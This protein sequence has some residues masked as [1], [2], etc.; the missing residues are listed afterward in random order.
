MKDLVPKWLEDP[1]A[2]AQPANLDMSTVL[3]VAGINLLIGCVCVTIFEVLRRRWPGMY[4]PKEAHLPGS[5][6]KV[7][8]VPGE[9]PGAPLSW[10]RPLMALDEEKVLRCGGYDVLVYL[11][12]IRMAMRI[13]GSFAPYAFVVLLPVN[14]SVFYLDPA[15]TPPA[16]DEN[17]VVNTFN[18]LS[19]SSMPIRDSRMWAHCLGVYLLTGLT[20][21]VL[22]R[23]SCWYARLRHRF[24]TERGEARQRTVLV[25]R[26]HLELRSSP[27]LAEYFSRLYPGKVVG[28]VMCRHTDRLDWLVAARATSV[29]CLERVELRR[30]SQKIADL[31]AYGGPRRC[32][33]TD[34]YSQLLE[35]VYDPCWWRCQTALGERATAHERAT[36]RLDD[37]VEAERRRLAAVDPL[38][39]RPS[40]STSASTQRGVARAAATVVVDAAV[41]AALE[42]PEPPVRAATLDVEAPPPHLSSSSSS[43]SS[44]RC[45]TEPSDDGADDGAS[46]GD[47]DLSSRSFLSY[48]DDDDDDDDDYYSGVNR[49]ASSDC[50]LCCSRLRRRGAEAA[51]LLGAHRLE[52]RAKVIGDKGFVT[53]NAFTG[54]TVATQVF[55]A[56]TTGGMYAEMAPEPRDIFWGN[57]HVTVKQRATRRVIAN[58]LVALLLVFYIVPVT[59]VSLVLS[60]QAIKARW[61]AVGRYCKSSIAAEAGVK[62]IHPMGLIGLMLLLPPFFLGLGFWEGQLSWSANTLSQLSRYYSFQITN[63]LLVTTVAGSLVKCL[64]KIIENPKLTFALLGESLPQVCAF[65]SC[66]IFIKAFSGLTIEL[67]RAVAAIQMFAKRCIYPFTTARDRASEIFGL[68]DFEHPGWFSYGKFGAQDLLVVVLLMTYSVMAPVILVPGLLF[69]GLASVVY[70]HQLLYVYVPIFESGGLLFP[71]IYRRTLFS[72]FI[73]HFTMVGIFF[74]KHAYY[75]GYATLA[76]SAG[77]YV[78]VRVAAHLDVSHHLAME[79]ATA[80]DDAMRYDRDPKLD[81]ALLLRGLQDYVQPGLATP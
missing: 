2:Y 1:S 39:G 17:G 63:V 70:R 41:V 18:R 79:L 9:K 3:L 62:M 4:S 48:D 50:Q 27:K 77:L 46:K 6:P 38:V 15:A 66:Y 76:L 5:T 19:V 65:F 32:S 59:L 72:V 14:A 68:R 29:A 8:H 11:R 45:A 53:F 51:A 26:V 28:A 73:L 21:H 13:F 47:G 34:R 74:L 24:S 10:V 57:I 12:F 7:L 42:T 43:S 78:Y 23:E 55:H 40:S 61:P 54:A 36:R 33:S 49:G 31:E 44:F 16:G 80:V 64:Q 22:A 30:A 60:E 52:S 37:G 35:D 25:Q 67:C 81:D 58:T 75:Q 56:A 71:R 69:L 20:M